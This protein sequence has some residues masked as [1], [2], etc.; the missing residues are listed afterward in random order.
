MTKVE[1]RE[2]LPRR[3]QVQ[4]RGQ[5]GPVRAASALTLQPLV[6]REAAEGRRGI[7]KPDQ[8]HTLIHDLLACPELRT[9]SRNAP[10]LW[11]TWEEETDYQ[12]A[13]RARE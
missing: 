8:G 6:H 5:D 2:G 4:A 7:G 12:G 11:G 3:G 10:V 1:V 9:R 13:G